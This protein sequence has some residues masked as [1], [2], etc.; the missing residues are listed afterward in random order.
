[1]ENATNKAIGIIGVGLVGNALANRL[2]EAGLPV[3]GHD[4]SPIENANVEIATSAADVVG[5]CPTIFLSLP[6][7][8]VVSSVLEEVKPGLTSEHLFI[9]TT[10]GDPEDAEQHPGRLADSG[11]SYLE[12][13]IAG[14]SDLLG[15]GEAPVFLGGCEK[16]VERARSVLETLTP[17][18]F[19]LG[20]AGTASRF[21]LVFNLV[22]GLHRA[23]LAEALS[24]GEALGFDPATVLD[25]LADSPAFSPVMVTKGR[26]MVERSYDPP[27]ARLS[28]HLKDVR[29]IL[30]QA[31]EKGV[32]VP[33]S[34]LHRELLERAEGLGFGASDTSAVRE[35]FGA[36]PD[37]SGS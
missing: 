3:V 9:D 13:T 33:L 25:V 8:E 6:T 29:L 23:V 27:Q 31:A 10:T 20:P 21:K 34:E 5:R 19:H 7:S 22:L 35:A 28:Q 18:L 24:F 11:A 32:R 36:D 4:L 26:R 16:D 17:R 14:S 2:G 15:K 12:A 37:S 30:A 1:M